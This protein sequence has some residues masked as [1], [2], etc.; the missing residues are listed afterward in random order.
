MFFGEEINGYVNL[1][2]NRLRKYDQIE[3]YLP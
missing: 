2:I 3:L 1:N